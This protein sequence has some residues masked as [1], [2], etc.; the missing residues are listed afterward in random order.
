MRGRRRVGK[1]TLVEELLRQAAV[2]HLFF[3]NGLWHVDAERVTGDQAA[4][5]LP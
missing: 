4:R 3:K 1:S 5:R 2:P